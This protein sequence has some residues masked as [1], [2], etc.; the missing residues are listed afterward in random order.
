[1]FYVKRQ[2]RSGGAEY[3]IEGVSSRYRW[4]KVPKTAARMFSRKWNAA[5]VARRVAGNVRMF[6]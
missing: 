2:S 3:L 1:M 4:A 5:R 6:E